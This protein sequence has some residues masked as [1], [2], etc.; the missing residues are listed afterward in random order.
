MNYRKL[1]KLI[2]NPKM[3]FVDYLN[4]RIKE[5]SASKVI[6]KHKGN[7]TVAFGFNLWK[8][9]FLERYIPGKNYEYIPLN[10][11]GKSYP[12]I[13]ELLMVYAGHVDVL[14]W[15]KKLPEPILEFCNQ[16]SIP[17]RYMED[18]FIRSVRLGVEHVWPRSLTIDS[19][20]NHFE[21][22]KETE[23]EKLLKTCS[24]EAQLL[25]R[26]RKLRDLIVSNNISKYNN[27][28]AV[29]NIESVYG[30][31]NRKRVLVIG[32]IES[33]ASIKFGSE[34]IK[35]TYELLKLACEENPDAQIIYKEHPDILIGK[36]T[37]SSDMTD[38]LTHCWVLK[39]DIP[40]SQAFHE[41]DHVYVITSLSGF[42][43][44]IRNI[45]VTVLGCPFYSGW[46]LTDDRQENKR[47]NRKL[48]IDELFAGAYILYPK[49]YN[50]E[51]GRAHV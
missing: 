20:A 49:Y 18:G 43:A 37:N 46:G 22:Q 45:N 2:I 24:F 39:K 42:E 9:D 35:T 17:V 44:L 32:Q 38:L 21:Y 15:G 12:K 50:I 7:V 11:T 13:K 30:K 10:A 5:D 41:V 8:R 16:K 6:K 51:I 23:L 27:S 40:L 48:T 26:S 29:D 1:R 47:R 28:R 4:K 36:Q 25:D 19:L 34:S 31:K 33:D 3:F 14:A